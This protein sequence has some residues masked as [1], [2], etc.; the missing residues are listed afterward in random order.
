MA[1]TFSIMGLHLR[2]RLRIAEMN[3]DITILRIFDD[4]L[5]ELSSTKDKPGIKDKIDD[6]QKQFTGFRKEIDEV[7][8]RMHILKMKLA[9]YA[10]EKKPLDYKTYKADNYEGLKKRYSDFRKSFENVKK[11]FIEFVSE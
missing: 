9:S 11:E 6:F 2:Y 8:D 4:Y 1:R 7:R 10:R 5:K 3:A